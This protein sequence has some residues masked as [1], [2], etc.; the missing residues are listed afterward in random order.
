MAP[1]SDAKVLIA[2]EHN[3]LVPEGQITAR[4]QAGLH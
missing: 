3:K 1:K 4:K 2:V